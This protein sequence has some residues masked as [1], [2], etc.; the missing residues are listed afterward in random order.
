MSRLQRNDSY[1]HNYRMTHGNLMPELMQDAPHIPVAHYK[2][3]VSLDDFV[4]L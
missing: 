3:K 2:Q 1:Y 4:F